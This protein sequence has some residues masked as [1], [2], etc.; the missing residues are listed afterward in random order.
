MSIQIQTEAIILDES[1]KFMKL[2]NVKHLSTVQ[3]LKVTNAKE[4]QEYLVLK[5]KSAG[6][7]MN[8][9]ETPAD[10]LHEYVILED[11]N[12]NMVAIFSTDNYYNMLHYMT[13]EVID[14]AQMT[15][16]NAS[17]GLQGYN[18]SN[19]T[20]DYKNYQPQHIN[21]NSS[22]T[23]VSLELEGWGKVNNF[24]QLDSHVLAHFNVA[25]QLNKYVDVVFLLEF[26]NGDTYRIPYTLTSADIPLF[27]SYGLLRSYCDSMKNCT[28]LFTERIGTQM[29]QVQLDAL[30]ISDF[31]W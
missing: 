26:S 5:I 17:T 10:Y 27:S 7:Y 11:T 4:L 12:H 20:F 24:A 18:F 16:S 30:E 19:I 15:Y 3:V 22:I 2:G 25:S 9:P 29:I 1:I 21:T 28:T 23:L 6:M 8:L 14:F 13:K 31:N